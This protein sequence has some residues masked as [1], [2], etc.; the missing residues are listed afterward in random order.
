MS[1]CH[2]T[3]TV[4][5]KHRLL[6]EER[7]LG[8]DSANRWLETGPAGFACVSFGIVIPNANEVKG[9]S[10]AYKNMVRLNLEIY[11]YLIR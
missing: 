9:P 8:Q 10:P 1:V 5:A 4:S 11:I 6:K 7:Y 2:G 3:K